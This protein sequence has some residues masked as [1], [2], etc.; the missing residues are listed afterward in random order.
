MLGDSAVTVP[1]YAA[2]HPEAS[3]NVIFIDGGHEETEASADI[4][5][6]MALANRSFHTLIVDDSDMGGVKIAWNK[7][8]AAG[9][10]G[11]AAA[12]SRT[13]DR[14]PRSPCRTHSLSTS[15][16][17]RHRRTAHRTTEAAAPCQ[18]SGSCCCT[19]TS[20]P[21]DKEVLSAAMVAMEGA[22][23]APAA[24]VVAPAVMAET[25]GK[26]QPL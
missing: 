24:M 15:N 16:Q 19:R 22:E 3:C 11:P 6:M 7:A 13:V 9:W 14:N 1:R 12:D 18:A 20:S 10:V 17:D 25:V 4:Y 8:V 26:L 5:H 23:V 2:A 21:V